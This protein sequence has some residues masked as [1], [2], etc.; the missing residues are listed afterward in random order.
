MTTSDIN[1]AVVTIF[2]ALETDHVHAETVRGIL[3]EW[4]NT[5]LNKRGNSFKHRSASPPSSGAKVD[6]TSTKNHATIWGKAIKQLDDIPSQDARHVLRTISATLGITR[7][8]LGPFNS[9][10]SRRT[11]GAFVKSSPTPFLIEGKLYDKGK[12]GTMQTFRIH[13]QDD[14]EKERIANG[15]AVSLKKGNLWFD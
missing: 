5:V 1:N 10:D 3:A 15:I 2:A 7:I 6:V 12:K 13:V 8:D 11:C 14:G 9:K 4:K